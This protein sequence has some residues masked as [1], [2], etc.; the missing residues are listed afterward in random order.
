MRHAAICVLGSEQRRRIWD[1][2]GRVMRPG[3]FESLPQIL[4]PRVDVA[5]SWDSHHDFQLQ[6]LRYTL[7]TVAATATAP[8]Y[9]CCRCSTVALVPQVYYSYVEPHV[10]SIMP[11]ILDFSLVQQHFDFASIRP[12]AMLYHQLE[13]SPT[14]MHHLYN[15]SAHV[16]GAHVK[17]PPSLATRSHPM[18][19]HQKWA[20]RKPTSYPRHPRIAAATLWKIPTPFVRASLVPVWSAHHSKTPK[21]TAIRRPR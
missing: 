16:C 20:A 14:P 9:Q 12:S 18:P 8:A 3:Q 11:I 17:R 1:I 15:E 13:H 4:K 19:I 7:P 2:M 10:Q 21:L 5:Y 6:M